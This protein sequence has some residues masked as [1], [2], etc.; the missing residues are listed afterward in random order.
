MQLYHF[1]SPNPQKVTF[2]LQELGLDCEIVPV[3]LAKGEHRQPAFLA[4]NPFGRVP[5]ADCRPAPLS[6]ISKSP[7]SRNGT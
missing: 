3:D 1:P 7:S 6:K 2:A 4:Q 5:V